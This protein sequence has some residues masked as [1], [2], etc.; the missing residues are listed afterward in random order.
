MKQFTL[1]KPVITEKS[2][3]DAANGVFTF[4][5]DSGAT[6]HQVKEVI[7]KTF[8]VNVTK[9]NMITRKGKTKRTGRKRLPSTTSSLKLARAW[10]KEGQNI[11]LFDFKE[12]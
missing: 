4:Q 2:M 5:V 6:K 12:E 7:E 3:S 8:S 9:V 11:S 10:L 1:I